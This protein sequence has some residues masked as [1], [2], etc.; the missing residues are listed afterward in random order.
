MRRRALMWA[1]LGVVLVALAIDLLRRHDPIGVDFHTYLA[2]SLVGLHQGW[3]HIYDQDLVTAQAKL[4]VPFGRVQPFLSPPPTAWLAAA[5]SWLPFSAAYTVW[6][7]F[8]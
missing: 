6:A 2:A 5:V 8:T 1:A 7:W 4:L 3:S